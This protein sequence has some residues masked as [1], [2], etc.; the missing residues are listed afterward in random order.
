MSYS[1]VANATL[2]PD[3]I[4]R[5][6]NGMIS[7]HQKAADI[8]ILQCQATATNIKQVAAYSVLSC[9]AS[10]SPLAATKAICDQDTLPWC[11][12][13]VLKNL[14]AEKAVVIMSDFFDGGTADTAISLSEQR[15]AVP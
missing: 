7:Q 2:A 13:N 4:I 11:R 3:S 15:L 10:N 9:N 5:A 12:N 14:G 6:F 1:D 8:T